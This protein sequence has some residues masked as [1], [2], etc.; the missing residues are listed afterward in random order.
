MTGRWAEALTFAVARVRDHVREQ[1]CDHVVDG[2]ASH[3]RHRL[4]PRCG[5]PLREDVA[6]T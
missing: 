4:C 6:T 1:G 5:S 3:P 2:R